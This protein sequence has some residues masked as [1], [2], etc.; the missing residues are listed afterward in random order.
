MYTIYK[1]TSAITKKSYVGVTKKTLKRRFCNGKGYKNNKE[2]YNDICKYGW[3][4]FSYTILA[5]TKLKDEAGDLERYYINKYNTIN[6]GYNVHEG[7]FINYTTNRKGIHNSIATE[8]KPGEIHNEKSVI[9]VE[10]GIIYPTIAQAS[11]E[12]SLG[13]HIGECCIGKRKTCGGYHWKFYEGGEL[14]GYNTTT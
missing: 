3:N 1:I 7:G 6:K 13:H 2:F 8:F 11:R 4:T 9:C 14:D 10:T 12:L 5:Q